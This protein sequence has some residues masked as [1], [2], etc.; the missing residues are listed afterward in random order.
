M[1]FRKCIE[2]ILLHTGNGQ[3]VCIKREPSGEIPEVPYGPFKVIAVISSVKME[4]GASLFQVFKYKISHRCIL[5]RLGLSQIHGLMHRT[6]PR[7][8]LFH[9]FVTIQG[10][11][12]FNG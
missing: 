3:N 2:F 11:V 9:R 10:G 5:D 12:V 4:D 1:L 8:H 7:K 6:I